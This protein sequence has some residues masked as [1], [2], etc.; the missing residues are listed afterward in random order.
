MWIWNS[1]TASSESGFAFDV[2]PG[3]PFPLERPKRSL[4]PP[5]SIWMLL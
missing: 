2:P 5:P 3:V 1:L 4:L